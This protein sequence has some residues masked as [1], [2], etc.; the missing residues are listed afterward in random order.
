[1]IEI[2]TQDL[3]DFEQVSDEERKMLLKNDIE[4]KLSEESEVN[5]DYRRQILTF[6]LTYNYLNTAFINGLKTTIT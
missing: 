3:A 5:R 1:M 4:K 6:W 2:D